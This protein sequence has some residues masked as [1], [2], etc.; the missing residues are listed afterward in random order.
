MD[1]TKKLFSCLFIVLF[2]FILS[3]HGIANLSLSFEYNHANQQLQQIKQT[4]ESMSLATVETSLKQITQLQ[5]Q[6]DECVEKTIDQID[7]I[8]KLIENIE[9]LKGEKLNGGSFANL[10]K[11]RTALTIKKAECMLFNF[12][13]KELLLQLKKKEQALKLSKTLQ[14]SNPIWQL[15][16]KETV[17]GAKLDTREIEFSK[18]F[19]EFNL[20]QWLLLSI[21]LVLN[22]VI[23][24]SLIY[25]SKAYLLLH[26]QC[27]AVT[28]LFLTTSIRSIP[29]LL[30]LST[31]YLTLI[32]PLLG[33]ATHSIIASLLSILILYFSILTIARLTILYPR[34][35]D[36]SEQ[37]Y[38]RNKA[39]LQKFFITTSFI[40]LGY[41]GTAF[42]A[43]Q[44][45]ANEFFAS[46]RLIFVSL[47]CIIVTWFMYHLLKFNLAKGKL[48]L[49]L[50]THFLLSL[51]ILLML[52]EWLGYHSFFY[53][54]I[55]NIVL[56]LLVSF[57]A[58]FIIS[59]LTTT[60]K[61][62]C[63]SKNNFPKKL[64]KL[65]GL[66]KTIITIDLLLIKYTLTTCILFQ[67]FYY[68]TGI[69]RISPSFVS[70]SHN[71]IMEGFEIGNFL[72]IPSKIIFALLVSSSIYFL[73]RFLTTHIAY[74][75]GRQEGILEQVALASITSYVI[76]AVTV[77][78]G[79]IIGGVNF[80]GLAIIMGALSVGIGFGLQNIAN[81]FIS[82]LI[83]LLQKPIKS[84]DRISIN[85][86]EGFVRQVYILTT[87]IKTQSREDVIIP[88]SDL[89]SNAVTNYMFHDNHVRIVCSVGVA[90]ESDVDK[91][92]QILLEVA[93]QHPMVLQ[94]EPNQPIALFQ[95]F[96]EST[97]NFELWG[98]IEDVNQKYTVV[99]DLN[100]AINKAFNE[101]Q[102][103]IA[104]PQR[105]VH[106]HH[107]S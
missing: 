40:T 63:F 64:R 91:V 98:V 25:K 38:R 99:S 44:Q 52:I 76:F 66:K 27:H 29:I 96:G 105:D 54:V 51:P 31:L 12:K 103:T 48:S 83:L 87:R 57:L 72:L 4:L 56:T 19:S 16:K 13:S 97:L 67:L 30:L 78:I 24:G 41:L 23:S 104:F 46:C 36:Y 77:L 9:T 47:A 53:Y 15:F 62:L 39:L 42:L 80:T 106:L 37:T 75:N 86:I 95:E 71:L 11:Q 10:D 5:D 17:T 74:T 55:K 107:S 7:E 90:Y 79:L 84:G 2:L 45:G 101:Q 58:G 22:L 28:T 6:A 33:L 93:A 89:T 81:N 43:E 35:S 69:W 102:I 59:I 70:S 49:T 61:L 18:V 8:S 14:R 68:L 1:A 26:K 85:N 60:I 100:F 88:N 21:V 94:E 73:G 32:S 34:H 92:K 3:A 65:L 82:G 20:E 50:L